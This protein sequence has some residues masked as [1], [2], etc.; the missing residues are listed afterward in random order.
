MKG[1]V[2]ASKKISLEVNAEETRHMIMSERS[3]CRAKSQYE[4]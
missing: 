4:D 1:L 3:E 2:V